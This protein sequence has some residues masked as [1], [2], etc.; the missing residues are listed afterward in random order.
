[1]IVVL[2]FVL[3]FKGCGFAVGLFLFWGIFFSV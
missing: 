3:V 1:M 2:L